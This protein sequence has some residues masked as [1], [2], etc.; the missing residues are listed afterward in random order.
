[1]SPRSLFNIILKVI[2]IICIKDILIAIPTL[3]ASIYFA[4]DTGNNLSGL[5]FIL[6]SIFIY[7]SVGYLLLFK[8][9]WIIDKFGIDKE[10]SEEKINLTIHRS[11]VLLIVIRIVGGLI[12]IDTLPIFINQVI[13]YWQQKRYFFDDKSSNLRF[14]IMYA[15]KLLVGLFLMGNARPIVNFIELKRRN[16]ITLEPDSSTDQ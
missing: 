13:A 10:L 12:T 6:F 2:G 8:S 16:S 14:V 9:E 3:F 5:L 7:C 4:F 1:M 15:I 11:V